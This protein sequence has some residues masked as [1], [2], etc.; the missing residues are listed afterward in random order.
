MSINPYAQAAGDAPAST[1]TP[2]QQRQADYEATIGPNHGFYLPKFQQFDEEGA[3]PGWNWPAFVVTGP[4][5]LYRK[6]IGLGILYLF[7][8]LIL[9][10][11]IAIAAAVL[12]LP[13]AV[14]VTLGLLLFFA[15]WIL[16]P[17]YANALYWR[18]VHKALDR[19]PASIGHDPQKRAKYLSRNG[20]TA[21]GEMLAILLGLWVVGGGFFAAISIPAYQDY[22]IRAQVIEGLNLASEVKARVMEFREGNGRWPNQEDL[23]FDPPSGK[24]VESIRVSAGSV[25]ILYGGEANPRL[26]QQGLALVPTLDGS[27]NVQWICGH[28]EAPEGATVGEGPRGS[29]LPPKYLPANCRARRR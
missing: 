9:L 3:R 14:T 13:S 18:R 16:V 20:G 23:D 19:L 29:D 11:V 7:Y 15:P 4:W 2:D 12:R 21:F 26:Q 28:A 17:M 6:M 1:T 25:V 22:T 27:N 5:L 8:P 24:Y 10:M